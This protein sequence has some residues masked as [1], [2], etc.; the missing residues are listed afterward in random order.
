MKTS[1]K[2]HFARVCVGGGGR[3][4]EGDM[5]GLWSDSLIFLDCNKLKSDIF[6]SCILAKR[7]YE[8]H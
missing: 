3:G 1:S 5:L 8:Q 2:Q 7:V 4:E 6:M